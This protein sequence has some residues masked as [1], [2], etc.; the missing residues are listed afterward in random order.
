[1]SKINWQWWNG[2]SVTDES[3]DEWAA[4]AI[5]SLEA[6]EHELGNYTTHLSG[7]SM[8][9]AFLRDG[10]GVEPVHVDVFDVVL[11]RRATHY[12][13]ATK[14]KA[15]KDLHAHIKV[16]DECNGPHDGCDVGARL[17][18]VC[19]DTIGFDPYETPYSEAT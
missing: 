4:D 9:I 10:D 14:T 5:A 13:E 18:S 8:V 16:C 17:E 15:A 12:P 6:D 11:R 19:L 2:K 7:D 3:R 1:M